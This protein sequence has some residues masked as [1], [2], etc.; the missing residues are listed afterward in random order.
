MARRKRTSA[1]LEKAVRRAA[2]INSIG[3][4]LDLGNGLTSPAFSSL[5]EKMRSRENAYNSALSN[6]DKL[7]REMLETEDELADMTEH[8][9]MA[10]GTRYGKSSVEYGMAGGVPKNQRRKGLRGESP[11]FKADESSFVASV[12]SK[13]GKETATTS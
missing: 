7:Y 11:T 4:N 13:N 9:L 10:V 3:S 8:M 5:I 1:V 6:L 2:G 12:Q